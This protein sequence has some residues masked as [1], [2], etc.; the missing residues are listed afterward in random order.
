MG[1]LQVFGRGIHKNPESDSSGLTGGQETWIL[2]GPEKHGPF[3]S[4]ESGIHRYHSRVM[5]IEIQGEGY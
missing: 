4:R 2:I 3:R 5:T 1:Y